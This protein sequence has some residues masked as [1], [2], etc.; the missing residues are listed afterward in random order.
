[1]TFHS[2]RRY[3]MSQECRLFIRYP[4]R[5]E[6]LPGLGAKLSLLQARRLFLHFYVGHMI[7]QEGRLC[8]L[9]SLVDR[10]FN[11]APKN[12]LCKDDTNDGAQ[13]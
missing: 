12:L 11:N 6:V 10:Q 3:N 5:T 8:R 2:N 4:K 1:M 13:E 7:G 9:G